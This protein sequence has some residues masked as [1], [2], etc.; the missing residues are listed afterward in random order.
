[1]KKRIIAL[2][3]AVQAIGTIVYFLFPRYFLT[4]ESNPMIY[5]I[6]SYIVRNGITFLSLIGIVFVVLWYLIPILGI[7]FGKTKKD[8]VL[9]VTI[10]SIISI[11]FS[12]TMLV[13]TVEGNTFIQIVSAFVSPL[14]LFVILASLKNII[15]VVLSVIWLKTLS[16]EESS[17]VKKTIVSVLL[18]CI[19][20]SLFC[21][22]VIQNERSVSNNSKSY[23]EFEDIVFTNCELEP[24]IA[25]E[26]V[27]RQ[28]LEYYY[29]H[30]EYRYL[31][32]KILFE[33]NDGFFYIS[34]YENKDLNNTLNVI[35][36]CDKSF[37]NELELI[38]IT[39]ELTN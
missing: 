15:I 38:A 7:M 13:L 27:R 16:N 32:T 22:F 25:H 21:G 2:T 20:I 26:L 10:P 29:N 11:I 1:M 17:V 35:K 5:W 23:A 6:Q 33:S 39:G 24:C 4:I 9:F 30:Q 36:K 8:V 31:E 18:I 3:I 37:D 12:T 19:Q 28:E 34:Q 14:L